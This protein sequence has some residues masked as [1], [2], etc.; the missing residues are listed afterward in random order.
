MSDSLGLVDFPVREADFI[1][2]LLN[3]QAWSKLL[4]VCLTMNELWVGS[5]YCSVRQVG[6]KCRLRRGQA[7]I[8]IFVEPPRGHCGKWEKRCSDQTGNSDEKATVHVTVV[9]RLGI[10]TE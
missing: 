1:A 7:K 8:L 3:K 4:A 6:L 2:H 9:I 5:K 10:L